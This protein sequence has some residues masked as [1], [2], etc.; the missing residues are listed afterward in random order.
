M[1]PSFEMPRVKLKSIIEKQID[2]SDDIF[3]HIFLVFFQHPGPLFKKGFSL[4]FWL[5]LH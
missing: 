4:H 2:L 3:V 5:N 1:V